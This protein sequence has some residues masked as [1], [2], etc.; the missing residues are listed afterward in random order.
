MFITLFREFLAICLLRRA[1]QDL[2]ASAGLLAIA[3]FAS[4]LG[5]F[6]IAVSSLDWP[7]ALLSAGLEIV[8]MCTVIYGL[9]YL[10]GYA[11]RW[12]QTLTAVAGTNAVLVVFALPLLAWLLNAQSRE[13]DPTIPSL[14]FFVL[15]IWNI[16][17]LA[18]IFRHALS[19]VMPLGVLVAL[20]YY[21][22]SLVFINWL[23]PVP[24]GP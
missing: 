4:G 19:I 17:I 24:A 8:F 18:H 2:P 16:V 5:S 9:L 11:S 1:P 20:M 14:L 12:W 6:V 13:A 10:P 22:L 7:L 21:A 23:I 3:L 15:I